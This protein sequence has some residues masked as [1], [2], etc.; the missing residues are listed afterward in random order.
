MEVKLDNQEAI[1]TAT[2]MT[3]AIKHQTAEGTVLNNNKNLAHLVA[4]QYVLY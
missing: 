2:S 1:R 3:R 4:L